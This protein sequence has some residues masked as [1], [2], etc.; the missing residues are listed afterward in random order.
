MKYVFIHAMRAGSVFGAVGS[1]MSVAALAFATGCTAEAADTGAGR[2]W[3]LSEQRGPGAAPGDDDPAAASHCVP[4]TCEG[5]GK[6]S[7]EHADGCG[8]TLRCGPAGACTPKTCQ[9]LGKTSGTADDGCGKT[10]DCGAASC[11]DAKAG[12]VSHNAA[13]DLGA[14][15]DYPTSNRVVA[16]LKLADGEEDWFK[17]KVTDAGFGGNPRIDATASLASAEV[18]VFFVCDSQPD[19]ST[20]ATATHAADTTIGKGCKAKGSVGLTTECSGLSENGTAYVRVKKS[21]S[22][23]QCAA[24]TLT[25][26]VD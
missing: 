12:N 16:D 19:Y 20:C 7:G 5:L 6:T 1:L 8:G 2:D 11:S 23:G 26:K 9:E 25:V 13:A 18:S 3:D 15:T 21:A 10:L 14:M 17:F 22:D 24:Y 4:K